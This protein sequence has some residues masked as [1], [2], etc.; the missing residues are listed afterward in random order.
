M[1]AT[2]SLPLAVSVAIP[3]VGGIGLGM[4][5]QKEV[6][7]WYKKLKKP[8]WTPPGWLFGPM[9]TVLYACMGTASW[10]VW[11]EGGFSAQALP[12]GVYA[13]QLA[14]NFAWS[15]LFFIGHE[16]GPALV[17]SSALWS[18]IGANIALFAPVSKPA[19]GLMVPYLSWVSIATA[20]NYNIYKNNPPQGKW[21]GKGDTARRMGKEPKAVEDSPE[22]EEKDGKAQ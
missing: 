20:L 4:L 10:L 3:L 15:P 12:L 22:E 18:C 7:G 16:I 21:F 17:D 13:L 2:L 11:K 1:G 5:T 8:S 14:L 19:A 6:T 9:W